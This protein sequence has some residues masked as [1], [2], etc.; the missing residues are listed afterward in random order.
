MGCAPGMQCCFQVAPS[1]AEAMEG[2]GRLGVGGAVRGARP[3]HCHPPA[4]RGQAWT[5]AGRGRTRVYMP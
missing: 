4:A 5:A 3:D 2:G 1:A